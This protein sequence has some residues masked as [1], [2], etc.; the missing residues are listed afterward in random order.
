MSNKGRLPVE[1]IRGRA[2]TAHRSDVDGLRA[3]ALVGVLAFHFGFGVQGGYGG[4]DVFF[5]ISG[6]LITG[7]I[8]SGLETGTFSLA[9][10]YDRRIRRIIPAFVVCALVTTALAA[11]ILLPR[12]FKAYG[13]TLAAAVTST[14]NFYF[15]KRAADYFARDAAENPLLHTW[16]LSVEAQ[17]YLVFPLFLLLVFKIGRRAIIPAMAIVAA[18]A[19][20][21]SIESV[22][23]ARKG[24]FFST[25]GRVW[26][27]L[28][29][30]LLAFGALPDLKNRAVREAEAVLGAALIAFAFF[31]NTSETPFP[32]LAALP[33]CLGAVLIIHSGG[34]HEPATI[35]KRALSWRPVV[36]LGLIS[37]SVYL[38]HWPLITLARYR[39]PHLFGQDA[40]TALAAKFVLLGLSVALGFL[41]WRFVE[42]P[43]RRAKTGSARWPVFIAGALA[44]VVLHV[45]GSSINRRPSN[46]QTWPADVVAASM[47]EMPL[48][49]ER[50]GRPAPSAG[51]WPSEVYE[52]GDGSVPADTLLW[53]DSHAKALVPVFAS[54]AEKTHRRVMVAPYPGCPPLF[55]V[56]FRG[57][58]FSNTCRALNTA[59][60]KRSLDPDIKRVI[61]EGYWGAFAPNFW[62]D[63]NGEIFSDKSRGG[64]D[65]KAFADALAATINLLLQNGKEVVVIGSIPVQSKEI[66]PAIIKSRFWAEP[67]PQEASL[68]EF[69]ER[70]KLV[71]TAF[72]QISTMSNVRVF[73]PHKH[74]CGA[75]TCPYSREGEPLYGDRHHLTP[76]GAAKLEPMVAEIFG[77]EAERHD[78]GRS[79]TLR[80]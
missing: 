6:F 71:M 73:Y 7:I 35:V 76:L 42:Q 8:K 47:T 49:V 59:T 9:R 24:A 64:A 56:T 43:F 19:L 53:G 67:L 10:F 29:G 36:G 74:L 72:D 26:E 65:G 27:L 40:A 69:L 55:D 16:S 1:A 68:E 75:S 34:Q 20:V 28:A 54:Y 52:I 41:S 51:G 31:T 44:V 57:G 11:T 30:A 2:V 22:E 45:A 12:D 5:V 37:Y 79:L 14:S 15:T 39:L 48:P 78:G 23:V 46:Y 50:F 80:H 61:L 70:Q 4:V 66:T 32:G 17:F 13:A 21:L 62:R 38:W 77:D 25:P 18:A 33:L 3:V 63:G 60:F 58:K